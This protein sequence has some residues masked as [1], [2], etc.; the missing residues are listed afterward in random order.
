[1]KMITFRNYDGVEVSIPMNQIQM[2][3]KPSGRVHD[4]GCLMLMNGT[5][6]GFESDSVAG[7]I[8]Q[9]MM[10]DSE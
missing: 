10:E 8:I 5:R 6:I 2:V 9:E 3:Q 1:V 7:R 4:W